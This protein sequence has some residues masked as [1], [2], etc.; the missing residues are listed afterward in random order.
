MV[1][2]FV[3][4]PLIPTGLN[5]DPD[6]NDLTLLVFSWVIPA[7]AMDG[8]NL[9]Y[10]AAVTG[11]SFNISNMTMENYIEFTDDA[12]LDCLQ[13]DFSVFA[14]N[15]AGRGPTSSIPETIPIC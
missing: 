2:L 15:D 14:S 6:P 4:V 1:F 13:H 5:L 8:V 7:D 9:T 3:D 11:P 12:S 10:T